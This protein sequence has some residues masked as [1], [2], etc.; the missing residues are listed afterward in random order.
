MNKNFSI[1]LLTVIMIIIGLSSCK[2]T[3]NINLVEDKSDIENF[4][5]DFLIK[6]VES[7]TKAEPGPYSI[8]G[9][10]QKGKFL[11]MIIAPRG[12]FKN[13]SYKITSIP[14]SANSIH[15]SLALLLIQ[16]VGERSEVIDQKFVLK[17][18]LSE[19]INFEKHGEEQLINFTN[20]SIQ[21]NFKI[22]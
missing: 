16:E 1:R 20:S 8:L 7:S 2:T 22:P 12:G 15:P 13:Y 5:F 18:D 6:A 4:E 19:V 21:I 9:I 17:V 3:D 11:E 10:K 14:T